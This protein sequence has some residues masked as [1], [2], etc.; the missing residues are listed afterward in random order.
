MEKDYSVGIMKLV[1]MAKKGDQQA[2]LI[3][4]LTDL[5]HTF[6][7]IDPEN[8]AENVKQDMAAAFISNAGDDVRVARRNLRK[9]SRELAI[10]RR[11]LREAS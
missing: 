7:T 10:A 5:T 8:A 1:K 6:E 2:R 4:A 9:V 11:W 3:L